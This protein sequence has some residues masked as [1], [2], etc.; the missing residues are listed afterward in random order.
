MTDSRVEKALEFANYRATLNNQKQKLKDQCEAN[1]NYAFNGGLFY[2][3]QTLI[4]F[5]GNFLSQGKTAMVVLDNNQTPVDIENL[6]EFYDSITTR[7]FES[8]NEYHRQHTE[9]ADKRKVHK[10]VD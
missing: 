7:W 1:L 8:V 5:I 4:S 9:L 6:Q 3:D 10:L 2:I